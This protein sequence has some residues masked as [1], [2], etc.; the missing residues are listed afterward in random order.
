MN[1]CWC[2]DSHLDAIQRRP[3]EDIVGSS[4][5]GET[6]ANHVVRNEFPV[7]GEQKSV[8][9]KVKKKSVLIDWLIDF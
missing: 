6:E 9:E 3:A 8:T 7:Q 1:Y 4:A 5:L 2:L